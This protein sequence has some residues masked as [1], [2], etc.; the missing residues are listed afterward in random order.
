MPKTVQITV[1]AKTY[2]VEEMDLE[3]LEEFLTLQASLVDPKPMPEQISILAKALKA[4]L[5]RAAPDVKEEEIKRG[6]TWQQMT[7]ALKLAREV[8][9]LV[10]AT[11]GEPGEAATGTGT[12]STQT[13]STE[14]AGPSAESEG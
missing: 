11:E 12:A 1:G 4:A 6:L 3:Q 10:Q 9:G 13:L 7:D 2:D 14:P 5:L 8:T